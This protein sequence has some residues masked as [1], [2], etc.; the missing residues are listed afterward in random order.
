MDNQKKILYGKLRNDVRE[1]ILI[2]CKYKDGYSSFR[3]VCKQPFLGLTGGIKTENTKSLTELESLEWIKFVNTGIE[4]IEPLCKMPGI[5]YLGVY[6]N[7]SKVVER[8]GE[9]YDEIVRSV[10]IFD[11]IP[12]DFDF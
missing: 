2:L 12:H 9:Q 1:I 6:G 4:D 5:D 8:Q 7:K 10:I 3:H 11:E